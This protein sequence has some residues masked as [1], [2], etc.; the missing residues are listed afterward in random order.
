MPWPSNDVCGFVAYYDSPNSYPLCRWQPQTSLSM[1]IKHRVSLLFRRKTTV[2]WLSTLLEFE[3]LQL[4]IRIVVLA[5]A[6]LRRIG[7]DCL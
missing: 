3:I 2:G 5:L 4:P 7:G 1:E 6:F